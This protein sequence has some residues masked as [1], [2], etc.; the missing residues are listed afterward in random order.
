MKSV[1]FI[2]LR[3]YPLPQLNT[4][5]SRTFYV[6]SHLLAHTGMCSTPTSASCYMAKH[7]FRFDCVK[8]KC[9]D[10]HGIWEKQ[11]QAIPP[12]KLF[13]LF[14]CPWT[15]IEPWQ[16]RKNNWFFYT[17]YSTH[18]SHCIAHN[19]HFAKITQILAI[20]WQH[21]VAFPQGLPS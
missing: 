5:L 11:Q 7:N 10:H 12:E 20:P 19:R 13:S 14:H 16:Q 6:C 3:S 17:G 4:F 2:H 21:P 18:S 8:R 1:C 9:I 15:P